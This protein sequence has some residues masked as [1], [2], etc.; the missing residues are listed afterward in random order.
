VAATGQLG[1]A[2]ALVQIIALA[3]L[4]ARRQAAPIAGLQTPAPGPL[5][6]LAAAQPFAATAGF[7]VTMGP[8][9]LI[10]VVKVE[11]VEGGSNLR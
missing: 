9:G 6:P 11:L 10:G 8:P 5:R 3:A 2:T 4:L 1:A 7:G